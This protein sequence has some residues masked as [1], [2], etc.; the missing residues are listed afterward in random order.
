MRPSSGG[1]TSSPLSA[2]NRRRRSSCAFDR[3][4]GRVHHDLDDEVAATTPP[5]V[6][7]APAAQADQMT[8]LGAGM[9][10]QGLGAVERLELR[11]GAQCGLGDR[12]VQVGLDVVARPDEDVVGS[13]REVH[14]EIAGAGRPGARPVPDPRAAASTRDRHRRERRR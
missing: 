8:G 2:A 12:H 11:R 7:D 9:D 3:L 13:H 4:G 10:G 14:V 5:H 6:R 1:P